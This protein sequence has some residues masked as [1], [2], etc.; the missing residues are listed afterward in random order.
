VVYTIR[1]QEVTMSVIPY[2]IG[3]AFCVVGGGLGFGGLRARRKAKAA[4]SWPTVSGTILSTEVVTHRSSGGAKH[5]TRVSYEP[6]VKYSY[7]VDGKEFK[8]GRIGFVDVSGGKG[9][10]EKRIAAFASRTDLV[11]HYNPKDP[12]EAV[13]DPKASGSLGL[14][15][16]GIFLIVVG[17]LV[18]SDA[19]ALALLFS[20]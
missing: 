11:V 12:K 5:G 16:I 2:V 17:A 10:A 4:S 19:P 8:D 9:A 3:A 18:L 1:R 6:V 20:F 7:S 13:L 15:A 14:F